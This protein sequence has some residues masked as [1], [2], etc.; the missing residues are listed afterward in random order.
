MS[1]SV[2]VKQIHM[3]LTI[4]NNVSMVVLHSKLYTAAHAILLQKVKFEHFIQC[5]NHTLEPI[6]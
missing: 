4:T 3:I 6:E 2:Y 5:K 1:K